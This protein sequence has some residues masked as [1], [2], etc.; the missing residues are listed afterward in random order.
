M[1]LFVRTMRR[2]AKIVLM[3]L[4]VF[5]LVYALNSH[6]GDRSNEATRLRDFAHKLKQKV[7]NDDHGLHEDDGHGY[8]NS[9]TLVEKLRPKLKSGSKPQPV[10][11]ASGDVWNDLG[12]AR[13]NEEVLMREKGYKDFAFNTLVSS[14]IGLKRS[15][16]DTRHK[17]CKK[18]VYNNDR[19]PSASVIVCY[20]REELTVLLRTIHSILDR[21]QP[22]LLRE[23]IVVNDHSDIDIAPNVTRHLEGEGLTGKVKLITPPERSGLIRARLYGAKH[24]TGQALVFLDSHVEVNVDW[25]EPLL[26]GIGRSRT[27]VVTPI[28][29]IINADTFDYTPSPLVRGGFNWGLNFKWDPIPRS[30][31]QSDADFASPFK[32]P[33]MAGGLFAIDRT[34]FDDLG[35]YDP[36]LNVWG[37]ENLELSFKVWMCGGTLEI[38]PCSRVG[39]VFRKRRPYG[40]L[41]NEGVDS[42]TRNSLRVAKVWMDDYIE[43]FYEINPNARDVDTGDISTRIDLRKKLGCKDFKWYLETVYPELPSPPHK[44]PMGDAEFEERKRAKLARQ[45]K[46]VPP[47]VDQPKYEPWDRKTRNYQRS[48]M[49]KLTGTN[50]CVE[51]LSK[52][53]EKGASLVLR[54]CNVRHGKHQV[55]HQTDKLELV[56]GKLVCLDSSNKFREAKVKKCHEL[57]GDQ[58][59]KIGD[60]GQNTGDGSKSTAIYNSAAGLCLSVSDKYHQEEAKVILDVCSKVNSNI[61]EMQNFTEEL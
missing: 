32:S 9:K 56:L 24:A 13:N 6:F 18:Q 60:E 46:V 2:V 51:S 52:V 1:F 47:D 61:W 41:R 35:G 36:G 39:H 23:I 29:D 58:E 25:L 11:G 8:K 12:V 17:E 50:Y 22:E 55:W 15:V 20:Y 54:T 5:L 57:G 3:A 27:N 16:P 43:F 7:G 26:D 28:I 21:T 34:F 42:M 38:L 37:G 45:P 44:G 10:G 48:F 14:R 31:L 59:W 30:E 33:T 40:N 19:M 49:L 4:A 53:P